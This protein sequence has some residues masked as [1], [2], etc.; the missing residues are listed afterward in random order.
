MSTIEARNKITLEDMVAFV[1]SHR[2]SD[3]IT[4]IHKP[5]Q[6]F[7]FITYNGVTVNRRQRS[8]YLFVLQ[9]EYR[10]FKASDEYIAALEIL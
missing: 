9:K 8:D 5:G 10:Y 2:T 4:F 6:Q 3:Y 7:Q 1:N